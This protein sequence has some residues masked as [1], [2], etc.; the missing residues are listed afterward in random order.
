MD[1]A[2]LIIE[3]LEGIG[4]LYHAKRL[5]GGPQDPGKDPSQK[6]GKWKQGLRPEIAE[7]TECNWQRQDGLLG[8]EFYLG[9]S[10]SSS[11]LKQQNMPHFFWLGKGP[12]LDWEK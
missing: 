10:W 1:L 5:E 2:G 12:S 8:N 11:S 3:H 7:H 4:C 6:I 9:L